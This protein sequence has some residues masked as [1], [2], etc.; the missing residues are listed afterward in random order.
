MA[1]EDSDCTVKFTASAGTNFS[2]HHR[3]RE[4]IFGDTSSSASKVRQCA[5]VAFAY[6]Y[7]HSHSVVYPEPER[8]G[9]VML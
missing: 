6:V 1:P 4:D 8:K 9:K 3:S 2:C 7:E 5:S